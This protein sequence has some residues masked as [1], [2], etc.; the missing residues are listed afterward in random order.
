MALAS[1]ILIWNSQDL[2]EGYPQT[3]CL[4]TISKTDILFR[5]VFSLT[6]SSAVLLPSLLTR[7]HIPA[8]LESSPKGKAYPEVS[9]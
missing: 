4:R 6:L 5:D 7:N 2:E 8:H 1:Y 3:V 9:F